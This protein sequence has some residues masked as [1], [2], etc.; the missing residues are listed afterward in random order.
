MGIEV[1]RADYGDER[2]ARDIAGLLN[3][4]ALDP[5]GGG[6]P[7][8]EH[9]RQNLARELSRRPHA[10]SILCYVDGEAAG[11]VNCFEGFSTFKCQPLVNIHD[12]VVLSAYR[13]R[14][15]SQR[16]MAK[17][18]EIAR[19][20]GCCK[21][22]LEV[23]EGNEAAQRAYLRFGFRGYQLDPESGTALFWEKPLQ[24]APEPAG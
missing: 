19:Q 24:A 21:L 6:E 16:M 2:Q 7:L 8:P 15:L 20:R 17:V 9:V 18:E 3:S 23:L 5:M 22:T 14:G 11:L 10:F 1:I 4:Y 13:G 12:V